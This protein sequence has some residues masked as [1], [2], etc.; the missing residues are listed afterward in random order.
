MPTLY[1]LRATTEA[2]LDLHWPAGEGRPEWSE[3]W[4]FVGTIPNQEAKGIY[5]LVHGEA[6][7]YIGVGAGRGSGQYK[8]AGLGSR[9]HRYWRKHPTEPLTVSGETRYVP[10]KVWGDVTEATT[11]VTL[12][13]PLDR[14]YLAY[15]LEPFLI[16]K[17]KPERN[18]IGV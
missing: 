4:A 18:R 6:V 7:V 8:N 2:F 11:I 13:L 16:S 10:S 15:A 1:D 14:F 3:P 9:L 12:G 17:L 5:A